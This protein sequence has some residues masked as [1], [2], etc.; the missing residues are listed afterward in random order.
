MPITK[1]AK[2]A[3]RQNARKKAVNDARKKTMKETV[4]L[5][6]K[7]PASASLATAYKAIDKA[8]KKHTIHK[9]RASRLKSRLAKRLAKVA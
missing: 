9:N 5:F 3:L 8:G 7:A 4:K 1:S 2:K 6:K